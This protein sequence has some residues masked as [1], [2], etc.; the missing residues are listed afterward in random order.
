M[1]KSKMALLLGG[2]A[3]NCTLMSG[4][5]LAFHEAGVK[6]D[7]FSAGGAGGAMALMYLAPKGMSREDMMR[8]TVNMSIS[9]LIYKV[10]PINYKMFL[11][12]T[13][14]AYAY[15]S[16]L[17]KLPFY[18]KI[19]NQYGMSK[20]EVFLS[21]LVQLVWSATTPTTTN[22]FSKGMCANAPVL[23]QFIDFS[24]LQTV[25]E[26]VYLNAYCVDTQ[27]IAIIGKEQIDMKSVGA[28]FSYPFYYPPTKYGEK[29]YMEGGAVD[30]YNFEGLVEHDRDIRTV[31]VLDAFGDSKYIQ[32]PRN[33]WQAYCQSMVLPLV[34]LCEK[35]LQL[36]RYRVKE[37]NEKKGKTAWELLAIE[38]NVPAS[39]LP[40]SLDW[41]R[42]N[43]ERMFE[44]GYETGLK[45]VRRVGRD[46]GRT[47]F[48]IEDED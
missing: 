24:K 5:L 7:V 46:L 9:D 20:A 26:E 8:N 37:R 15:R 11:K 17:S 16:L 10:L 38:Y 12:G 36:L 1:R 28:S 35:D 23:E 40:N 18:D 19:V 32:T 33:L 47:L 39:W 27:E 42:T 21:D 41:S 34:Q 31:V 45:H 25:E 44:L 3:P 22:F 14:V 30:A 6:F 13:P 29:Y 43:M 2:G 4:T 48:E